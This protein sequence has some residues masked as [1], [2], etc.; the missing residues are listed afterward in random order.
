[1]RSTVTIMVL[2]TVILVAARFGYLSLFPSAP[3]KSGS[4]KIISETRTE[5]MSGKDFLFQLRQEGSLPGVTTNDHGNATAYSRLLS[6]PYSMTM[7]FVKTGETA[8]NN[9]T[10]MKFTK[11]SAWQLKRA[12]RTDSK[13]QVI[14]E[15]PV[16]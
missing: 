14:E 1:M 7:G 9:Y 5:T 10:I 15:W 13:G 12:W 16:K 3:K 2:A 6:Y 8:T 4:A 11:D